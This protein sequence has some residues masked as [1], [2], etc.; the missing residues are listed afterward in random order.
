MNRRSFLT[1]PLALLF[2][3][4]APPKPLDRKSACLRA[5]ALG[6][7][8]KAGGS[9]AMPSTVYSGTNTPKWDLSFTE[10]QS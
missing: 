2:P 9:I 5:I 4:I 1:V 6:Q 3:S 8:L 7:H 10:T